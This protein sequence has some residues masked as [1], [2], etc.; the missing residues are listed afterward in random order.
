MCPPR[1]SSTPAVVDAPHTELE[2]VVAGESFA[3]PTMP[4][5]TSAPAKVGAPPVSAASAAIAAAALAAGREQATTPARR[6]ELARAY[7]DLGD[8][9]AARELLREVLDGRDP[10]ARDIAARMLREL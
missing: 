10:V 7:L 6:V 1:H 4:H 3:A 9:G 8:E 2:P 5:W